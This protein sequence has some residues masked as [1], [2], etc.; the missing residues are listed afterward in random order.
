MNMKQET[1]VF[2][3]ERCKNAFSGI[4]NLKKHPRKVREVWDPAPEE[5]F[6]FLNSV[7]TFVFCENK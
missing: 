6:K 2:N 5:K 1:E 4:W 3:C 7:N